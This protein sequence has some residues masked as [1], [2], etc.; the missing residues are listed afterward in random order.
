[1]ARIVGPYGFQ[2]CW[3]TAVSRRADPSTQLSTS[4]NTSCPVVVRST[5][6]GDPTIDSG[7]A[8]YSCSPR[9][10]RRYSPSLK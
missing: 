9:R 1:M 4:S 5:I 8:P 10:Y 3:S 7:M 2:S 6:A